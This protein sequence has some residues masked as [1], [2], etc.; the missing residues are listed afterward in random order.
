MPEGEDSHQPQPRDGGHSRWLAM[1]SAYAEYRRAS[2]ALECTRQSADDS[3]A[4]ERL[5]LTLLEGQQRIAFERYL[6]ARM[7]FLEF[8]FDESNRPADGVPLPV[9][10]GENSAIGSWLAFAN[11]RPVLPILAVLLL[12]AT[13]FSVVREEKRVRELE[14]SRDQLQATLN[15]TRD[16]LQ[17]LGQKLDGL[18]TAQH[19]A[20]RQVEHTPHS[21]AARPAAASPASGKRPPA[22]E[23]PKHQPAL[24]A[25][26]KRVAQK[27]DPAPEVHG[28]NLAPPAYYSFSLTPSSQFKR[29]G[30]IELALRSVDPQRRY[31]SLSVV[32]HAV[33][34]DVLRLPLNKPVSIE[35]GYHQKPLELVVD[36]IAG[37]RLDGR[38]IEPRDDKAQLGASRMKPRLSLS[39]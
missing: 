39:P 7:E 1:Q 6:E 33:K 17:M 29:V 37:N 15:Q 10:D 28:Q 21:P 11:R 2:E 25:Q 34:L 20:I 12:C 3:T 32:S 18:G 30:P 13:A 16:G 19:S 22:D 4:N 31:A 14:A 36:R 35:V 24:R 23:Q 5:R 27:R 9:S 38:L 26:Q 8:R